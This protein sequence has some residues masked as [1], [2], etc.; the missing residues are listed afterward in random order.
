MTRLTHEIGI[1]E[2]AYPAGRFGDSPQ[3]GAVDGTTWRL[4]QW[5]WQDDEG[6]ASPPR[7]WRLERHRHGDDGF[8]TREA[9]ANVVQGL[10]K[11]A[12][13]MEFL[14]DGVDGLHFQ[15]LM[16]VCDVAL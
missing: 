2:V 4:C 14:G 8:C 12:E 13:W 6:A 5:S 11:R 16:V 15:Y 10:A 1:A 7:R 3:R 9:D